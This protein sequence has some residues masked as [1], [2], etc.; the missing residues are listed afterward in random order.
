MRCLFFDKM[1]RA[2]ST[3]TMFVSINKQPF[4]CTSGFRRCCVTGP[5]SW[6]CTEMLQ[7]L[8]NVRSVVLGLF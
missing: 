8:S 5:C 1:E 2:F 3:I 7:K 4:L 6:E